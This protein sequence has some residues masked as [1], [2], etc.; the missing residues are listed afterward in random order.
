MRITPDPFAN[1]IQPLSAS[2]AQQNST[3]SLL[4]WTFTRPS[5]SYF[6]PIEH[7]GYWALHLA[8]SARLVYS[9][10]GPVESRLNANSCTNFQWFNSGSTQAAGYLHENHACLVFRGTQEK[11]IEDW[12]VD[13]TCI[14]Y[15]SPGRHLGF[16]R[17]WKAVEPDVV[18]WLLTLPPHSGLVTAGHSLGGALAILSAF[19]L[20]QHQSISAV[21][22]FG[23]P[24]VG[25]IEFAL[26]YNQRLASVTSQFKFGADAVTIIPPP[27]L[28]VHVCPALRINASFADAGP[29]KPLSMLGL[30]AQGYN[31]T[32]IPDSLFSKEPITAA[33]L[34]ALTF[35]ALFTKLPGYLL[36]HLSV[37]VNAIAHTYLGAV[38]LIAISI[39][40]VQQLTY[41][42]PMRIPSALR[43]IL[44]LAIIATIAALH[45]NLLWII[46]TLVWTFV[47][48]VFLLRALLPS[49]TDHKMLGY[50]NALGRPIG[51]SISPFNPNIDAYRQLDLKWPQSLR[52]RQD[53]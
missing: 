16:H 46:P 24:R 32:Q 30:I 35:V 5:D 8:E 27:P 43:W 36:T 45:V 7:P 39:P 2:P 10:K 42:I 1:R 14:L 40:L 31:Y 9:D 20:S 18:A 33:I 50:L 41:L 44:S 37:W 47:I 53:K 6:T 28:F 48:S 11:E 51:D 34:V 4:G 26:S 52:R 13:A 21:R 23:A 22:T 19:D 25:A 15:G 3:R 49:A 38:A 12:G 17:A 29:P